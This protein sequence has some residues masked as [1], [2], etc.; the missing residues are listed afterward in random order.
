MSRSTLLVCKTSCSELRVSLIHSFNNASETSSVPS[1][2]EQK[3]MG[4]L[5][6]TLGVIGSAWSNYVIQVFTL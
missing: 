5:T 2:L 4:P 6:S 3:F 1:L